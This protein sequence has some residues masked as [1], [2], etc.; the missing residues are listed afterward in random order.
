MN[1][2]VETSS[3]EVKQTLGLVIVIS[4]FVA[5]YLILILLKYTSR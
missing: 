5:F 4:M 3:D 2:D 1:H